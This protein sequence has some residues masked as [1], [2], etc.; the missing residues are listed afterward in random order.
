MKRWQ[1]G[2][3][4]AA[5]LLLLLILWTA[6]RREDVAVVPPPS[7]ELAGTRTVELFFPGP[8]GGLQRETREIL[9]SDFLEMD[10]SRAVEELIRGPE[11]GV[12]PIPPTTRLLAAFF[13]GDGEITLSFSDHLRTEHPG[14]SEAEMETIRCLV[15]TV[16]TNFPGVDR[17]RILVEG[18]AVSTLAGHADLSRPLPVED[19][20]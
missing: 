2:A 4:A 15:A 14:G 7:E 10:V 19:Y 13:D 6:L 9:G 16:G 20:L 5:A 1:I 17:V 11:A 8:N 18:D 3:A 12:R